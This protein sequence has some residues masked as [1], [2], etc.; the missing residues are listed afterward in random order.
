MSK[1]D[2]QGMSGPVDPN[3]KGKPKAESHK[4]ATIR[5]RRLFTDT[6]V[7]ELKILINEVLDEREGKFDY[8]SYFDTEHF[9]HYVGEEEPPYRPTKSSTWTENDGTTGQ[10]PS[11]PDYKQAYYQ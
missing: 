2:T 1:I 8:T 3:Y 4:P 9:K 10:C 6:Y 11:P 5:P 7:K